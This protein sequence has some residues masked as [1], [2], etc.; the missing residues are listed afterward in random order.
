M[1]LIKI[2]TLFFFGILFL[3]I[4]SCNKNNVNPNLPN[5]P[6]N[7]TID[8][9]STMIQ[10][11]NTVGGWVY[12]DEKPGVYIPYGSRGIMVYR[13]DVYEFRAF[14]RQPPNEP[15]KCCTDGVCTKML[16]GDYF[17]LAVDTCTNTSYLL[18]DG[19]Q[20]EGGGE[21]PLIQYSAVYDGNLL[22]IYN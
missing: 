17:P 4:S 20:V 5:I 13:M 15:N 22:H 21:Y 8:P 6:I 12:L 14:E 2:F 19:S 3:G 1:K 10:E 7:I 9:N 16:I 11:L 18:I